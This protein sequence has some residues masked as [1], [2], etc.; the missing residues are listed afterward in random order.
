MAGLISLDVPRRAEVT[1]SPLTSASLGYT[2][3]PSCLDRNGPLGQIL[4]LVLSQPNLSH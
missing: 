4:H 2:Y 1:T 3:A